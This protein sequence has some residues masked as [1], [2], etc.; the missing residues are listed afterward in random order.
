MSR[1]FSG[2]EPGPQLTWTAMICIIYSPLSLT[3]S[4][5]TQA[6]ALSY[7]P[8]RS[9]ISTLSWFHSLR[10]LCSFRRCFES[11]KPAGSGHF[12]HVSFSF[13]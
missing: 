6:M 7:P 4:H 10:H 13:P 3:E 5:N 9:T 8:T 1:I 2:A 12:G 11:A